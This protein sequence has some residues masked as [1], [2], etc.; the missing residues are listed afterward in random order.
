MDPENQN[1]EKMKK[2]SEYII[3]LQMCKGP[4]LESKGIRAIFQKKGRKRVKT[5]KIFENLGENV[6]KFFWK[7]AASCARPLHVWNS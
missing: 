6:Q 5:G 3:I 2:T 4:V 7:R 1:F